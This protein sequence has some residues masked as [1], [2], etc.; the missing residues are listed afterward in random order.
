M[1]SHRTARYGNLRGSSSG[2]TSS[3]IPRQAASVVSTTSD[4][5]TGDPP[6]IPFEEVSPIHLNIKM[7]DLNKLTEQHILNIQRTG[8][9]DTEVARLQQIPKAITNK[10]AQ[11]YTDDV[12][13]LYSRLKGI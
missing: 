11:L 1:M 8:G 12:V 13:K 7:D 6:D 5:A 2:S 3:F 4:T 9:A 10:R